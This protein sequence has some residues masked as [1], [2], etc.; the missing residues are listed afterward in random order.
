MT[1]ESG[2]EAR[3]AALEAEVQQLRAR[4]EHERA[5]EQLRDALIQAGAAGALGAPTEHMDLLT[6][7][8]QTAMHVIGAR[9]GSLYLVD[10]EGDDLIFQVALGERAASL[11]GQ[12]L[13]LGQGIAGWVAATGQAIAVADVQKDPR[14]AQHVA[15]AVGYQPRSMLAMPLSFRDQVIGVLQL[16]DK[17]GGEPFSAG[18]MATLGMFATQAA[19]AIAQSG[20]TQSLGAL[21]RSLLAGQNGAASAPASSAVVDAIE[22]SPEFREMMGLAGSLAEI[23][24]NGD[25][26][27]R[28]AIDVVGAITTYLGTRV[29][30]S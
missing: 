5:A 12:R 1:Q 28:L 18:D 19:V 8:V 16:L 11:R 9:A 4:L 7:I 26:G 10:E 6:Q 27:R 24:R 15:G 23:A 3:I 25:A 29:R 14:W 2:P 13:P 30:L 17:N 22:Q 20:T 21:L